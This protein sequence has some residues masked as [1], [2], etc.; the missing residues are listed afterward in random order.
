MPDTDNSS[1]LTSSL[2][3]CNEPSGTTDIPTKFSLVIPTLNEADNIDPLLA[4]LFALDLPSNHFEVIFADDGSSDGTPDKVRAW[5]EKEN[6]K[7]VAS[8]KTRFDCIN[9]SWC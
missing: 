7:L 2:A 9:L 3:S 5:G 8:G 1:S 4:G 6:V